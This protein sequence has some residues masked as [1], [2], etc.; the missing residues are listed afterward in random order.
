MA[1]GLGWSK[2]ANGAVINQ[3]TANHYKTIR[4]ICMFNRLI[5]ELCCIRKKQKINPKFSKGVAIKPE[6]AVSTKNINERP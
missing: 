6:E 5:Y 1:W 2:L 4:F 3:L